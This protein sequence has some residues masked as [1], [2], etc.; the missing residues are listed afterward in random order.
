MNYLHV[1]KAREYWDSF[2][3]SS[4]RVFHQ[5][6]FIIVTDLFFIQD[7]SLPESDNYADWF[8]NYFHGELI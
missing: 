2:P 5:L 1:S 7:F 6:N 8:G 4:V 3:Q